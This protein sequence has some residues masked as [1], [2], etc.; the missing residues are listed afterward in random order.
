MH[1]SMYR[2]GPDGDTSMPGLIDDAGGFFAIQDC[3][4]FPCQGDGDE[5]LLF[6]VSFVAL[7]S[8]TVTFDVGE[9]ND[10]TP[11][12]DALVFGSN[13]PV[14]VEDIHFIDDTLLVAAP[15][16][17][18]LVTDLLGDLEAI[19]IPDGYRNNLENKLHRAL[20]EFNAGDLEKGIKKMNAF[21]KAVEAQRGKKITEAD[22]DFLIASA[23]RI[24]DLAS[25]NST[26]LV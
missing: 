10:P 26:L 24:I 7:A 20:D 18:D 6:T 9:P 1:A 3:Q 4:S 19:D 8:G 17:A 25:S 21:I 2:N 16:P 11:V 22:A 14:A 23:T 12:H 15:T 13:E 5:E